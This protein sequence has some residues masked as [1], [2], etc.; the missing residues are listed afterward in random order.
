MLVP[1]EQRS[2]GSFAL[3]IMK[4]ALQFFNSFFNISCPMSKLGECD[5]LLG[6]ILGTTIVLKNARYR[7]Q[8][9]TDAFGWIPKTLNNTEVR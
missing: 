1:E 9:A 2:Q 7:L 8:N 5:L 3:G 4:G 6:Q